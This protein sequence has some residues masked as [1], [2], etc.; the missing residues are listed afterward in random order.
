MSATVSVLRRLLRGR[1]RLG[2][3]TCFSRL[4][5]LGNATRLRGRGRFGRAAGL[6]RVRRLRALTRLGWCRFGRCRSFLRGGRLNLRRDRRKSQGNECEK[7]KCSFHG[8]RFCGKD[9]VVVCNSRYHRANL[10]LPDLP[11]QQK[12]QAQSKPLTLCLARPIH[13]SIGRPEPRTE[14]HL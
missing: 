12:E 7:E 1:G 2:G 5:W 13:L 4:T 10:S 9:F 6:D 14:K 3:L 11:R 8:L